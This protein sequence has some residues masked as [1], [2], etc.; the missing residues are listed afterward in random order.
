MANYFPKLSLILGGTASGKSNFAENLARSSNHQR[1]YMAT[2]QAFDTEMS[3]KILQHQASRGPDWQ[4]IETP[5]LLNEEISKISD[6]KIILVDCL[7]LWLSNHLLAENHIDDL[8]RDLLHTINTVNAP[9]ILVSNEVGLGIV[10]DNQLARKFRQAQ[11]ELNQKIAKT[12]DLVVQLYAGIP[13]P[14]KGNLP[15]MAS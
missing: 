2:A 10:P 12:A 7:T 3:K 11:G 9:I 4:T 6:D 1:V 13:L 15:K 5:F 8:T 14:I